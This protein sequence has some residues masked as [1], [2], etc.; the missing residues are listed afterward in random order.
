MVDSSDWYKRTS[1]ATHFEWGILNCCISPCLSYCATLFA[2]ILLIYFTNHC[3]C[4]SLISKV[5]K[6]TEVLYYCEDKT[7]IAAAEIKFCWWVEMK[8]CAHHKKEWDR[9][10]VLNNKTHTLIPYLMWVLGFKTP[11]KK[12]KNL[13]IIDCPPKNC[14]N[15]F[16]VSLQ[17]YCDGELLF[18]PS[19]LWTQF[20]MAQDLFDWLNN[21]DASIHCRVQVRYFYLLGSPAC[22]WTCEKCEMS[23]LDKI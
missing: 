8:M 15:T 2:G 18:F 11:H 6:F 17:K 4:I 9:V 12:E 13:W 5:I 1:F 21:S 10:S 22:L 16:L 20:S 3:V 19:T 14:C 23:V 7:R